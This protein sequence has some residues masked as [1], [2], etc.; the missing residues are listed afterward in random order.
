LYKRTSLVN[1]AT[2]SSFAESSICQI[3][4]SNEIKAIDVVFSLQR[5]IS[6]F[7]GRE[8]DAEHEAL[9]RKEMPFPVYPLEVN[10]A[11]FHETPFIK[12]NRVNIIGVSSSSLLHIG[13]TNHGFMQA[14]IKHIREYDEG[15]QNIPKQDQPELHDM[16]DGI[17]PQER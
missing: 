2:V 4:D 9:S 13:S 5:R 3:G 17:I 12:V 6:V 7:D 11:I 1:S 15:P 14:K 10:T 16:F 8:G